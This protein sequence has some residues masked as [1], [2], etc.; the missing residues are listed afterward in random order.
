MF[1][2]NKKKII[3]WG[4]SGQAIVIEEFI[5]ALGYKITALFDNNVILS[6]PFQNIPVYYGEDGFINWSKK[7]DPSE[8]FFLVTIGGW[9]GVTRLKIH[10]FLKSF[11]LKP[12]SVIHPS[13]YVAKNSSVG[14]GC[15]ILANSFIGAKT[16]VGD[17]VIINSSASV[18][19]ECKISDG[20]HLA[21]GS[22]IAGC[23]H[24][25]T[26]SFIGAGASVVSKITLGNNVI[27]G[28][29]SVVTKSIPDNVIVYGNPAKI[30]RKNIIK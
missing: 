5:E 9:N 14:Y 16:I 19:H 26:N 27:I 24:I 13:A 8:H 30:I 3:F 29:G 23:V 28:A 4:A 22:V 1:F 7:N 10:N 12:A 15:Q 17:Q 18:D 21:P 2:R 11:G 25:G 20:V 6:S